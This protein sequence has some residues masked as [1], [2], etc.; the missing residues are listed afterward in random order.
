MAPTRRVEPVA[1]AAVSAVV[2][3]AAAAGEPAVVAVEAATASPH[4]GAADQASAAAC[5][6][7][8]FALTIHRE[9]FHP[10]W[11]PAHTHVSSDI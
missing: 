1:A 6:E 3:A 10:S 8:E 2:V 5:G 4:S 7:S 9:C 11:G